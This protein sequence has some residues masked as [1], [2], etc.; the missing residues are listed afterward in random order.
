M[1]AARVPHRVGRRNGFGLVR[2]DETNSDLG[3]ADS[4]PDAGDRADDAE[5]ERLERERARAPQHRDVAAG[6]EAEA[7]AKTDNRTS[8]TEVIGAA[9]AG[10]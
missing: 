5:G 2:R 8:H 10:R 9:S 6:E 3:D 7:A 1:E 4:G